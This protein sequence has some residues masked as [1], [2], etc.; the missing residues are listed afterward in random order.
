MKR[1]NPFISWTIIIF[2]FGLAIA[3][4]MGQ[5]IVSGT[6]QTNDGG[7]IVF[8][9]ATLTPPPTTQSAWQI[10][11][12]DQKKITFNARATYFPP[13]VI[14]VPPINP[15][16]PA[17]PT[18][19]PTQ[20]SPPAG[21]I[22]G[23]AITLTNPAGPI[24]PL[25]GV[26]VNVHTSSFTDAQLLGATIVINFG[27]PGSG[28][29]NIHHGFSA[30]HYYSSAGDYA[31]SATIT[32]ASGQ[33]SSA[34][35]PITIATDN[36]PVN[37]LA[38]GNTAIVNGDRNLLA[39]GGKY[40]PINLSGTTH[41][42]VGADSGSGTAPIV[43]GTN[44]TNAFT[45]SAS[46]V[47]DTVDGLSLNSSSGAVDGCDIVGNATT[48]LNCTGAALEDVF[49]LNQNPTNVLIENCNIPD[50]SQTPTATTVDGYLAWVQG[51]E[52][53]IVN[54]TVTNTI[55]QAIVRAAGVTDLELAFDNFTKATPANPSFKNCFTIQQGQYFS[56]Y[57]DSLTNGP[58]DVGPLIGDGGPV[59]A[60]AQDVIIDSVSTNNNA[61]VINPNSIGVRIV[62]GLLDPPGETDGYAIYVNATAIVSGNKWQV[63][64][65]TIQ[66]T[67][68][69][70]TAAV[71]GFL[72][73]SGGE[74]SNI[75]FDNN[76]FVDPNLQIGN[77]QAAYIW[78]ANADM[79]S[80]S[81]IQNNAW[82]TPASIGQWMNGGTFVI[83]NGQTTQ[84]AW[85]T[86]GQWEKQSLSG[87]RSPSGDIYQAFPEGAT[88]FSAD[89]VTY[90]AAVMGN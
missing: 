37:H 70:S 2:S 56:L 34:S 38:S 48:F 9:N 23:A 61:I 52:I 84:S 6:L 51:S 79:N 55:S 71:T 58:L 12:T 90:G 33:V 81:Q 24:Y 62:N 21:T 80:F 82:E 67:T 75:V 85:I 8:T 53:G 30:T 59:N 27:D 11:N 60:M 25:D 19:L 7:S 78:N 74:A 50:G 66:D 14:V 40:G 39:P 29:L 15:I 1:D 31:A 36:R 72:F 10:G 43:S 64:N 77:T 3:A 18:T 57:E 45:M 22:P 32:L 42:F 44:S 69:S 63:Q 73:L 16:P 41:T 54:C 13:P 65:L 89:G 86:P 49:N 17:P 20:P 87:G 46:C 76:L 47:G 4:A 83:G 26:F 28:K 35:I 5:V 88:S 68:V